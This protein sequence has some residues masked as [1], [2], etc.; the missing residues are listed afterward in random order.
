M[1]ARVQSEIT[2]VQHILAM[3]DDAYL[4]GHPEWVEILRD[5]YRVMDLWNAE[6]FGPNAM[7]TAEMQA[8]E[9]LIQ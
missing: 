9:R 5:C 7:P 8:I 2:L 1:S 4:L 6:E 3:A